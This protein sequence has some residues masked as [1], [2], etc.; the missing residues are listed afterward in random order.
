MKVLSVKEPFATLIAIGLKTYESRTW[1]NRNKGEVLLH[2]SKG[3]HKGEAVV[4]ILQDGNIKLPEHHWDEVRGYK[5]ISCAWVIKLLSKRNIEIKPGFA[6]GVMDIGE[7]KEIFSEKRL[8]IDFE[9]VPFIEWE[10]C[11]EVYPK[12]WVWPI[13]KFTEIEPFEMKGSL[14]LRD[15]GEEIKSQINSIKTKN[16]YCIKK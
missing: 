14:G 5:K 4:P 13:S 11:C 3:I 9:D 7:P 8:L 6:L 10:S 12:M 16:E 2:A 15:V 1:P